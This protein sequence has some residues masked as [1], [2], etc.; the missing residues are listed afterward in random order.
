[1]NKAQ[2]RTWW[3]FAISGAT[4]LISGAVLWYVWV[5][6]IILIDIDRPMLIRLLGMAN[7]I[8]LIMIAIL[9]VRFPTKT[10]DERDIII[11]HKSAPLGY[12][13]AFIFLIAAGF[14][15]FVMVKPLDTTPNIYIWMRFCY[16][17]YLAFFVGTFMSSIA[18]LA[19]YHCVGNKSVEA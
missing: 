10:F 19:Q 2:T 9:S 1:M 7:A 11:E 15:L 6:E 12:I 17:V 4:L 18:S 5:H 14:S 8:P 13:A 3:T 16:L